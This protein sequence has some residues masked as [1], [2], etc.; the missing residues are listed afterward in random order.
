MIAD[1]LRSQPQSR[2]SGTPSGSA[3]A[4]RADAAAWAKRS[5]TALR[6]APAS[7]WCGRLA[8][9][10]RPER[11]G[12]DQ[13]AIVRQDVE[14]HGLGHGEIEPV[15]EILVIRPFLVGPEIGDARLDLHDGERA[16]R[17]ERDQVGPAAV[18][19][20]EFRQGHVPELREQAAHAAL[21]AG[22]DRRLAA[23]GGGASRT[24]VGAERP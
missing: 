19:E 18:G 16:V 11:I 4:C 2:P 14:R 1:E 21:D 5:V 17:R 12:E 24:G 22:R 10:R 13:P 20:G 9:D 23:V 3:R 6:R 8:Q 7:G 15:A